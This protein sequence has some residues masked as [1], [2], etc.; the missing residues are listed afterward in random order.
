MKKKD[1]G[2]TLIELLVAIVI[3]SILTLAALL[4]FGK[5]DD[6]DLQQDVDLF[7]SVARTAQNKALTGEKDVNYPSR[8]ICGY[9]VHYDTVGNVWVIYYSYIDSLVSQTC[10]SQ[11]KKAGQCTCTYENHYPLHGSGINQADDVFFSVPYGDVYD[12]SVDSQ[13]KIT[14][15]ITI[16][17]KKGSL[18]QNIKVTPGGLIKRQ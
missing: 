12:G 13:N 18:I 10:Q 5:N 6:R 9:G 16:Q 7:L 2:F 3:I 15:D 14:S 8:H 1:Y 4:N 17:I 11:D